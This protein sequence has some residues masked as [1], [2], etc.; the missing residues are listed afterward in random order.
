MSSL[1]N[2]N[3]Q[4]ARKLTACVTR[5]SR[6]AIIVMLTT[7]EQDND[8][9]A[10]V[11]GCLTL[12]KRDACAPVSFR[13]GPRLIHVLRKRGLYEKSIRIQPSC[14][15]RDPFSRNPGGRRAR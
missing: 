14:F 12:S 3:C 4:F 10:T 15:Q 8:W 1:C 6:R 2:A 13:F 9:S 5:L 11:L 7:T